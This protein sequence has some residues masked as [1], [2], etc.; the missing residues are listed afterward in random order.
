MA[1]M[2][3]KIEEYRTKADSEGGGGEKL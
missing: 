3:K 2:A 1:K